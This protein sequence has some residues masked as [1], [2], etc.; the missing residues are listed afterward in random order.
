MKRRL[1]TID[2]MALKSGFVFDRNPPLPYGSASLRHRLLSVK[3]HEVSVDL[4]GSS[5]ALVH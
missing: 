2:S 5:V 3:Y 4:T 1:L